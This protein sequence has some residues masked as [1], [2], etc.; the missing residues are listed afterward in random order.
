M[1]LTIEI[2][3]LV[4]RIV[5]KEITGG[6]ARFIPTQGNKTKGGLWESLF[7]VIGSLLKPVWDALTSILSWTFT[8]IWALIVQATQFVLNFDFNF[9]D[10]QLDQQ[11]TDAIKSL[12]SPLGALAGTAVGYLVCG[13]LPGALI[14]VF[15]QPMG[16]YVLENVGEKALEALTQKAGL[17]A[18]QTFDVLS[19]VSFNFLFKNIRTLWRESDADFKARL[20]KKGFKSADID[21]SLADRNKPWIISQK[22]QHK[23]QSIKVDWQRQFVDQ[24]LQNFGSSCVEAG[25]V[26]ANS[27][28]SYIASQKA[29]QQGILGEEKLVEINFNDDGTTTMKEVPEKKK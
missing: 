11:N 17:L 21:K 1:G 2:T 26:V 3:E 16:L 6:K 12:A 28:D 8:K 19:R 24:F 15:D 10:A 14:Y 27:L 7:G 29:A 13:A 25:Y 20:V 18:S 9:P 23:V 4:S 22:I 5:R